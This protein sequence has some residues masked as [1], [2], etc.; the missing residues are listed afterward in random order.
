MASLLQ[1]G[2]YGAIKTDDTTK[3]VFYVI[4]F[5]SQAHTL[6]NNTTIGGQ[7]ISD[8]ELFVKE[9]YLFSM[10][11][12]T[13]WY[14]KQQPLQQTIIITTLTI[15]HPRLDVITI[16]NVQYTPK[17]CVTGFRQKIPYK[18]TLLV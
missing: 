6:K 7:V 9:K 4:Q 18:D 13:N 8:G 16:R 11:K 17:I 15:I 5:I 1:S 3:N 2:M 12:N 14:C 10:Q